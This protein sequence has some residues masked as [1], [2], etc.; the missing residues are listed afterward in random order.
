MNAADAVLP[1]IAALGLNFAGSTLSDAEIRKGFTG[2]S[3]PRPF[4][5]TLELEGGSTISSF[6][7]HDKVTD[8]T[9][10]GWSITGGVNP[11]VMNGAAQE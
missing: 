10:A 5:A 6:C 7:S 1:Q 2:T 3:Q 11:P 8:A 9:A 4:K